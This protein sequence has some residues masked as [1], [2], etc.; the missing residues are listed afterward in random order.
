[1]I[2][3]VHTVFIGILCCSV[4]YQIC[5]LSPAYALIGQ[6][7]EVYPY[8]INQPSE[9]KAYIEIGK[10][11]KVH[12][13]ISFLFPPGFQYIESEESKK[14][15]SWQKKQIVR[16]YKD[17]SFEF[18]FLT[19]IELD[20]SKE[21]YKN[22][23]IIIPGDAGI[24]NPAIPGIYSIHVATQAEP[25]WVFAGE[26]SITTSELPDGIIIT[27]YGIKGNANWFVSS[28][29]IQMQT[30]DP[31]SSVWYYQNQDMV[32]NKKKQST[33]L[34]FSNGQH[35]IDYHY[36]IENQGKTSEWRTL[37][38][39]IDTVPPRF[40]VS[41][42]KANTIITTEQEYVLQGFFYDDLMNDREVYHSVL[43]QTEFRINDRLA[44]INLSDGTFQVVLSLQ[45][46]ENQFHLEAV[47]QA[48]NTTKK[49]ITIIR[50][51]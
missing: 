12:E 33:L 40:A 48:G 2:K 1:M 24:R 7:V 4:I 20:P 15:P 29:I 5:T 39:Y 50:N 32:I 44:N 37:T 11:L 3:R 9:I 36:C 16:F 30:I 10:T 38:V 26:V 43:D 46:G 23:T 47:D 42:T 34:N 19:S 8:T 41:G 49:E 18:K 17:G 22:I 27:E 51:N 25:D 21:G 31:K 28:P 35:I 13:W 14:L 45:S 6:G